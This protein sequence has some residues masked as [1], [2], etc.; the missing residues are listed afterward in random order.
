M[1][2][3]ESSLA[4]DQE[5]NSELLLLCI[6]AAA[7]FSAHSTKLSRAPDA[8]KASVRDTTKKEMGRGKEKEEQLAF[9]LKKRFKN[10]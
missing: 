6:S 9:V 5:E 7:F 3:H 10:E 1:V 8:T 2:I 4:M